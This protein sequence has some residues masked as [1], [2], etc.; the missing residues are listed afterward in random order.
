[1]NAVDIIRELGDP[2][3]LYDVESKVVMKLGEPWRPAVL[4]VNLCIEDGGLRITTTSKGF[5]ANRALLCE[6]RVVTAAFCGCSAF[7]SYKRFAS[8]ARKVLAQVKTLV[9]IHNRDHVMNLVRWFPSVDTLVL[10]HDLRYQVVPET[11]MPIQ[12]DKQPKL[13]RLLGSTAAMGTNNLLMDPETVAALIS[14]CPE[15]Y[16]VQTAVHK[17]VDSPDPCLVHALTENRL[18]RTSASLVL[19]LSFERMDGRMTA[20]SEENITPEIVVKASELFPRVTRLEVSTG[21]LESVTQIC[22]F[23]D[24]TDLT[25]R[26]EG[27]PPCPFGHLFEEG[28]MELRLKHLSL[29]NV[30]GI[31][32][33][34][35]ATNWPNLESISLFYC[36]LVPDEP[37]ISPGCFQSL[38]N[39]R[40][41]LVTEVKLD[42]YAMNALFS[43]A[44]NITTLHLDGTIMCGLF[45]A[46][47]RYQTFINIQRLTLA[48]DA[49]LSALA[50]TVDDLRCLASSLRTLRHAATDSFHL[51]LSFQFY[52]PNVKLH[53]CHCTTC[54]AEFPRLNALQNALWTGVV[55]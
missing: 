3:E 47:C 41:R 38:A 25:L 35:I 44:T 34:A 12:G 28:L 17:L 43:T 4:P 2:D 19:G 23:H 31:R 27:S 18:L 9:I 24:V 6:H 13:K 54:A 30:S 39:V 37:L 22:R 1:M 7:F 21:T 48:T 26:Y 50:V 52:M 49:Q 33:N 29:C 53:W 36:S 45:L 40:M 46:H 32:L 11:G 55:A 16:E 51:R 10:H 5:V 8:A 15:L 42:A 20:I 14:R